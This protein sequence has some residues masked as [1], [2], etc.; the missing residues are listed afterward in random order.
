[1]SGYLMPHRLRQLAASVSRLVRARNPF[2]GRLDRS[3]KPFG[4]LL[5]VMEG[6]FLRSGYV[7]RM[8]ATIYGL[9][10]KNPAA[11]REFLGL[12]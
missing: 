2:M 11:I 1:M 8:A 10:D 3:G 6:V 4:W 5:V 9:C 7:A 12:K